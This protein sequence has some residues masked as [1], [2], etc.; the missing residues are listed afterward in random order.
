MSLLNAPLAY[1]IPDETARVAQAAFPKG[2]PYMRIR[3]T[4]GPIFT[5]LAFADLFPKDGAPALAPA[6]LALITVM[7][8]A[9]NLADR[10]AA[11][12]VRAR[13]DWKY[14][15][16]LELT[17]PG[18]DASVW[19]TRYGRR[20]E[21]YRLPYP[22]AERYAL[23][24]AW[25]ADGRELLTRLWAT[26]TD[27]ALR[28]QPAVQVLRLVWLQQFS[29]VAPDEPMRWRVAKDLP[30]A[31]QLICTPYDVEARF[32]KKRDTSWVGYK[33]HLT[34]TCPT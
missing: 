33:V 32:S 10:Q 1:V 16:A 29:A 14:A 20:I 6:R 31:P 5:N 24:E 12:A 7:Q 8:F 2:N 25:G 23:A 11:D 9:E 3:D 4:L 21:E 28:E 26:E 17:D 18:F 15:L 27:P 34:M 30:P 19:Y 22:K 13:I